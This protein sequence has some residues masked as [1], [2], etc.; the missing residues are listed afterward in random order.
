MA[1]RPRLATSLPLSWEGVESA[2]LHRLVKEEK[3]GVGRQ[4]TSRPTSKEIR[5]N[6]VPGKSKTELFLRRSF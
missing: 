6:N 4:T 5:Y 2:P 1:L 3:S